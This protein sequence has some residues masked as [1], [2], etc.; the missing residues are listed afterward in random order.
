[1]ATYRPWELDQ[2]WLLPPSI[3]EFVPA[4]HVAQFVRDTVREELDLSAILEPYERDRRGFPA[5]HPVMMTALLL[6]AYCRG[7]Y[8]SRRIAR[9]CME[10]VDF[11]AVTGMQ[12]PDFRTIGKFRKRHLQALSET[13]VQVLQLCACAGLT[14]LGHVALDGTKVKAA[15]SKRKA[16]S[17]ERMVKAEPELA[18]AVKDWFERAETLDKEE[19]AEHGKRRGDEMPSWVANKQKRLTKIREAKAALEA[20]AAAKEEARQ[21][22]AAEQLK[23]DGTPRQARKTKLDG[24]PDPKAQRNFSDPESRI[25]KTKDGFDQCYNAQAVVDAAS[26]VIVAQ[27]LDNRGSD[28]HQLVPMLDQIETNLGR[29]PR[30]FSAD[31]GYLSEANLEAIE[32][33]GVRGYVALGRRRHADAAAVGGRTVVPGTR[34]AAMGLRLRRGGWRSRYRLRK[35]TVETVFGNIK[36]ARNFDGFLL[37]GEANVAAEWSLACTAH[38]LLKLWAVR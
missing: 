4:G 36:G 10:R 23:K 35:Q 25:M 12:K 20:E 17:Y 29:R 5:Y 22:Q 31:A 26:H 1:M 32:A 19:D 38:N 6:Y 21:A 15:A 8:S 33:R 24:K 16:M 9:A 18:A 2:Q 30:E 11:M 3:H 37:R 13:F 28:T 27:G 34:T 7:I 14:K